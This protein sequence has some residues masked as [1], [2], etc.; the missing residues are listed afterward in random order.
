MQG[1]RLG[2]CPSSPL[3]LRAAQDRCPTLPLP[4]PLRP[5]PRAKSALQPAAPELGGAVSGGGALG[6]REVAVA[7]CRFLALEVLSRLLESG[8]ALALRALPTA[9][10]E[11]TAGPDQGHP[12][13][14]RPGLGFLPSSRGEAL[15]LGVAAS[16]QWFPFAFL[17]YPPPR[18]SPAPLGP[19]S[20]R[21]GARNPRKSRDDWGVRDLGSRW[22]SCRHS[23][24][25]GLAQLPGSWAGETRRGPGPVG[26]GRKEDPAAGSAWACLG[27]FRAGCF[28]VTKQIGGI[29]RFCGSPAAKPRGRRGLE[30][31]TTCSLRPAGTQVNA[32]VSQ[33]V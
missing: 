26:T 14:P 2:G 20:H 16:P 4:E 18:P 12:L 9:N 7:G 8:A 21:K 29:W 19:W 25:L 1:A 15:P 27:L 24:G 31:C 10:V 30:A 11:E 28:P 6:R 13:H 32:C 5:A 3:Q 33:S 23:V 22:R 17:Q